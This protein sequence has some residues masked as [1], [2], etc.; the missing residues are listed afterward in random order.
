MQ[1][2]DT[3]GTRPGE[4]HAALADAYI[5]IN[6]Y[7]RFRNRP[8]APS[9]RRGLLEC[10]KMV[11]LAGGLDA[12]KAE[13]PKQLEGLRGAAARLSSMDDEFLTDFG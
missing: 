2:H 7:G 4:V 8:A 5:L 1:A 11:F 6:E 9:C 12:I 10:L 13:Y 3:G